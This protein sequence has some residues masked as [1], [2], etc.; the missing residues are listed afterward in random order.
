MPDPAHDEGGFR[1][2]DSPQPPYFYPPYA[3]STLRAPSQPL[4]EIPATV[5]EASGPAGE[6]ERLLGP[7]IDDLTKSGSG[8][9]L[10]ERIVICGRVTDGDGRPV[11]NSPIEIWQANAAGRYD[12][13]VDQHAAPLDPNFRGAGRVIT[14]DAGRYRFVTIKP[15]AYPWRN[16]H[17]AWRPAHIHLSLF[18]PAF[19]SRLVTQMYFQGDPLLAHDPIAG[20]VP[21]DARARLV[22][23]LDLEATVP[24]F[25]LGYRFDIVLRGPLAT[26]MES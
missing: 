7:A 22:A 24:D 16:H 4:V 3:S 14:D 9:P 18:G 10:G 20:S 21:H 15:G 8:E 19:A 23:R 25:A 1:G 17:N 11:R 2:N 13:D 26:P 5:S 12:H 6:W